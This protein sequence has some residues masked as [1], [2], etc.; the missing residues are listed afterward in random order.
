LYGYQSQGPGTALYGS[1]DFESNWKVVVDPSTGHKVQAMWEPGMHGESHYV[2]E[3][4]QSIF[5]KKI[6]DVP[7][8][9]VIS[10]TLSESKGYTDTK[11]RLLLLAKYFPEYFETSKLRLVMGEAIIM[12]GGISVEPKPG[13]QKGRARL[14]F[15]FL[16]KWKRSGTE[17][18]IT[19]EASN[20]RTEFKT[21][22]IS[23][24]QARSSSIVKSEAPKSGLPKGITYE[25]TVYRAVKPKYAKGAWNIHAENI[26][27]P[28]RYSDV[29][30]GALYSGTSK[31]AV[32]GELKHYGVDPRDFALVSKKVKVGNIL[33]LTNAKVRKQLGISL[34]DLKGDNYFLTQAIG[35]FARTRYSG[36]LVPSAREDGASN[37]VL[38]SK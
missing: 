25:G 38:F 1:E 15:N 37:L 23:N 17:K 19:Q 9:E 24:Q 12:G 30:R 35:D 6:A 7:P 14:K 13:E 36:I 2:N 11:A 28:H 22:P 16:R 33:D 34:E 8:E 4:E 18:N 31:E 26:G 3:V 10:S 5:Q 21:D 20:A 27:A 32:L 29:G